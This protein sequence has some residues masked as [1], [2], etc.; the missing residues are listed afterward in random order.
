MRASEQLWVDTADFGRCRLLGNAHTFRGRI[1]AWSETL[2]AEVT[3]SRSDV[4]DA[5][6]DGWAWIDGFLAGNEPAFHEFLGINARAA[7]ALPDGDP[8]WIRYQQ[9]LA[10]FRSTGSMPFPLSSRPT[11]PPPSGLS[12][13]PWSAAGGE[14]LGWNGTAWIPLDPPPPLT[15]GLLAGSPCEERGHHELHAAGERHLHCADCGEMTEVFPV[16]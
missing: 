2:G 8:G 7:D 13:A 10:H 15:S 3:I 11:M 9:A 14:V 12:P 1:A 4:R 5:T 6:P 16:A